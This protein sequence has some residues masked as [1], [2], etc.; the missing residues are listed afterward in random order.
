MDAC[1]MSV[2]EAF[3]GNPRLMSIAGVIQDRVS[4]ILPAV[5]LRMLCNHCWSSILVAGVPFPIRGHATRPE[6]PRFSQRSRGRGTLVS[7]HAARTA[8]HNVISYI[9]R[10]GTN[11]LD[12]AFLAYS[13]I[14]V[15]RQQIKP[16]HR[17]HG[18]VQGKDWSTNGQ[19]HEL[20]SR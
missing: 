4:L 8:G 9:L 14:S 11:A 10:E 3:R 16:D 13:G 7:T 5:E 2:R 1:I 17:V 15:L 20:A 6:F 18:V 19:S 12:A